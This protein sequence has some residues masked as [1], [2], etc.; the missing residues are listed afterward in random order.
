MGRN[1]EESANRRGSRGM[2]NLLLKN[3]PDSHERSTIVK[4]SYIDWL[5]PDN[6][7]DFVV[8]NMT[9]HHLWPEEKAEIYRKI[10]N[11]L[12]P[13]GV[14]IEG[15]FTVKDELMVKQYKRR[16]EIITTNLPD[17]AKASE[18]HIDIP[19][20]LE[21]QIKLLHDAGFSSI[22]IVAQVVSISALNHGVN[23]SRTL[24]Y[25]NNSTQ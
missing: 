18:Y 22:E 4:A 15:D 8:S 2:L 10:R 12:K 5:Y 1:G 6:A 25:G 17:K 3:H 23:N 14:Y 9:M 19:C 13:G 7:I 16:Y 24:S 21:V 20:T 11:A